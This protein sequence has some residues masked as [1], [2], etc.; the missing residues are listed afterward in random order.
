LSREMYRRRSLTLRAFIGC[1]STCITSQSFIE[2][3]QTSSGIHRASY[4]E[5]TSG[6]LPEGKAAGT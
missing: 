1:I 2:A 3:A 6:A 5:S 4:S